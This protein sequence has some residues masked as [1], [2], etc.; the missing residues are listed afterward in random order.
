[1]IRTGEDVVLRIPNEEVLQ[2][3]ERLINIP[4]SPALLADPRLVPSF[5]STLVHLT[6][7]REALH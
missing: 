5:N 2:L 3:E 7:A 6:P 4:A 1:M